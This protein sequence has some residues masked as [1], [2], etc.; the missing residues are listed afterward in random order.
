MTGNG[1]TAWE[2]LIAMGVIVKDDKPSARTRWEAGSRRGT[3]PIFAGR[4]VSNGRWTDEYNENLWTPLY[5]ALKDGAWY[6]TG[7][8]APMTPK[9]RRERIESR[10]WGILRKV[11]EEE[12]A[13]ADE[14]KYTRVRYFETERDA[15]YLDARAQCLRWLEEQMREPRSQNKD[16]YMDEALAKFS[17]L[18]QSAFNKAWPE[19]KK[20]LHHESWDRPGPYKRSS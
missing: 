12:S 9:S 17:G 16:L 1:L 4:R 5:E 15:A 20:K 8:L 10:L 6:A 13:K 3:P 14:L 11:P 18:T 19:A 2:A 7:Y